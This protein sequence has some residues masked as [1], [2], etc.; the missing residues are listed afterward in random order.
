[1]D[2]RAGQ[3]RILTGATSRLRTRPRPPDC[4][5]VR[6][7]RAEPDAGAGR[8][9]DGRRRE[10]RPGS[11]VRTRLPAGGNG[12]RTLGPAESSTGAR[13][14]TLDHEELIGAG[15]GAPD[16]ALAAGEL[17]HVGVAIG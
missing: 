16:L 10:M 14:F 6:D 17:P 11:L 2:V 1:M 3:A 12:I 8:G 9:H 15:L 4:R 7:H 5:P 13:L